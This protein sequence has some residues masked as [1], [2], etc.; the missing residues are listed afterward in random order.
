MPLLGASALVAI[1]ATVSAFAAGVTAL[2]RPRVCLAILFLV[3]SFSRATLETPLGTMRPEMPAVAVVAV[4]LLAS[5]RFKT[6]LNV[7]RS[8]A[9]MALA[10]GTFLVVMSLSSVL[11]APDRSQS[12]HMVAW[13]ALSMLSGVVAFVLIRPRP[14]DAVEPFALGGATMGAIGILVAAMFLIGGPAFTAGIQEQNSVQPRVYAMAWETNLY[15]SFLAMT[16]FLALEAA[17]RNWRVGLVLLA[18]VLIG[19]PLGI[20]RGAYL[21]LA[22]GAVVY[23]VTRFVVEHRAADLPRLGALAAPL[24]A[25]G[26]LASMTMLPN[27]LERQSAQVAVVTS[28][29]SSPSS[30]SSGASSK[31]QTTPTP[32]PTPTPAP[33]L[34]ASTDT[35]AFRLERVPVALKDL[36]QSPIIGFGAESF[37]ERHPERS[38]GGGPD[39]IAIMAV[40]VLYESG[41]A[42]AAALT[43]GFALLLFALWRSARRSFSRLD[44]RAAGAAAAFLGALVTMLVAYQVTTSVQFAINWLIIGAAA[45]LTAWDGSIE[46]SAPRE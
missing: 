22:A 1:L 20:T 40:A 3:A 13:Y 15:A 5:G 7:P 9:A 4:L 14:A 45:A 36:P 44:Y 35:V 25:V 43:I 10:F 11:V 37:G 32:T 42:G 23:I 30:Q 6:L 12:M 34:V 17:R 38:A 31:P 33:T 21:G 26:I 27:L 28:T 16:A 18:L 46:A 24:L 8:T 2:S 29:P 41:I 19:F 39:H